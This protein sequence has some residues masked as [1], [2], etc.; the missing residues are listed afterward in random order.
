[1]SLIREVERLYDASPFPTGDPRA[2]QVFNEFKFFLNRG[3][4]RAAEPIGDRWI[5]HPWVKK[6]ILLGFRLGVLSTLPPAGPFRFFDNHTFPV[7]ELTIERGVRIVPGGTS[8]RDGAYLAPGVICMPPSYVNVGA[9]VEAGTMID[10]HVLVGSCAQIGRNVHIGAGTVIGGVLEPVGT[11]PVVLEDEVTVGGNA[12]IFE[13]T[14][15]RRGAVL[16]AGVVITGSTPVY[17]CVRQRILR[18]EDGSALEIP[19]GAVVVPGSRPVETAW[20]KERGLAVATPLIIKYRD[21]A[22]DS[23]SSREGDLR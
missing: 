19:P 8:I 11:L 14:I 23:V 5:V 21:E 22:T 6:G 16:G 7:K 10:S 3:E 15:I 12:G 1:M 17:D 18:R 9:R 4:I 2:L 20:A 13:G